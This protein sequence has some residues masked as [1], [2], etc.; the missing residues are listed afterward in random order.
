MSY[1]SLYKGSIHPTLVWDGNKALKGLL[2]IKT[3]NGG[4]YQ[5]RIERNVQFQYDKH[6]MGVYLGIGLATSMQATEEMDYLYKTFQ[7]M[8]DITAQL[9]IYTKDVQ[10]SADCREASPR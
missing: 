7:G 1:I 8:T 2:F 5:G 10:T 4:S 6:N 3:C 9:Y